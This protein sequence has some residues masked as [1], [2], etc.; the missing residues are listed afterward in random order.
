MA[1][2]HNLGFDRLPPIYSNCEDV[3]CV[4]VYCNPEDPAN[5]GWCQ[6]PDACCNAW[7]QT[8]NGQPDCPG[9]ILISSTNGEAD[10]KC[11]LTDCRDEVPSGYR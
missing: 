4:V 7:E 11:C 9:Y 3:C 5:E 2:V 10:T 1:S 6:P 8:S